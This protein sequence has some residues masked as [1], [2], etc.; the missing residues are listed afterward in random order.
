TQ[1]LCVVGILSVAR[2]RI[3]ADKHSDCLSVV[4]ISSHN[5]EFLSNTPPHSRCIVPH[6]LLTFLQYPMIYTLWPITTA[7]AVLY[8]HSSSRRWLVR[9]R[10][11]YMSPKI[12]CGR[13][14]SHGGG[15][16]T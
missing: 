1:C 6:F 9:A 12:S 8:S 7:R 11:R 13:R 10:R 5:L 4:L 2:S 14:I 16:T 3:C 15:L